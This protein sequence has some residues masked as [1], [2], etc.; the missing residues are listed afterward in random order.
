MRL[1]TEWKK[2]FQQFISVSCRRHLKIT[3]FP[4]FFPSCRC[5]IS[6]HAEWW[7]FTAVWGQSVWRRFP[8]LV[9]WPDCTERS[10]SFLFTLLSFKPPRHDH[11][12][13]NHI[14][15]FQTD[16]RLLFVTPMDP[17]YLIL[18]YL[19]KSGKEVRYWNL[20]LSDSCGLRCVFGLIAV[21]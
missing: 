6:V 19:I 17:L 5:N 8:L 21:V 15:C 9:Y 2:F 3:Q 14:K 16:G 4:L 7:W 1:W 10:V 20:H 12:H 11:K 18:P 13:T